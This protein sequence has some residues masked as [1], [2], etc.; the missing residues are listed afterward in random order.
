[1]LNG[2]K[3]VEADKSF[4]YICYVYIYMCVE[5]SSLY[6]CLTFHN[7]YITFNTKCAASKLIT[8]NFWKSI[9]T[10][11]QRILCTIYT[12]IEEYILYICVVYFGNAHTWYKKCI[13]HTFDAQA[14]WYKTECIGCAD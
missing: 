8:N 14:P 6:P 2:R 9:Y 4:V 13:H 1:M 5:V 7:I 11:I 3:C 12:H 10:Y